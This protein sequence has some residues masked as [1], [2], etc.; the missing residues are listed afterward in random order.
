M[1]ILKIPKENSLLKI[2]D[3]GKQNE[4]NKGHKK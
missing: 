2:L 3:S 4:M 1:L